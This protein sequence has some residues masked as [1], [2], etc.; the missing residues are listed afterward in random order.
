MKYLLILICIFFVKPMLAQEYVTIDGN[1]IQYEKKGTGLP[2][3]I[4]VAGYGRPMAAFDSVFD[5]ISLFTTVIRY[6]RAGTG[7]SSYK[8]VNKD[9]DSTVAE[10]GLL[11]D[12]LHLLQPL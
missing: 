12:S 2:Y 9:F 11:I 3:I 4:F 7:N 1:Q 6:S 5:Q 10:L 8:N